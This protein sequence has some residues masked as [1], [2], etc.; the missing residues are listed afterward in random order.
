MINTVNFMEIVIVNGI[1]ILLMVLL[2]LSRIENIEK[3]FFGD[4]VFDV[5]IWLTIAGCLVEIGTFVID[6]KMFFG[7]RALSYLLNSFCFIGTCT[8]GFLWCLFVD[9]RI[10]NNI[11]RI[12]K[13][14]KILCIPLM[15]DIVMNVINLNGCGIV[16]SISKDNI[17]QRG[18]F[19]ISTYVILFIYFIYSLCLV[20]RSK[21]SDLR[22]RFFPVNYFVLPCVLGTIVQGMIYGVTLGWTMV[23]VAFL[24]VHI[25]TQSLNSFV[26]SLSGLYNRSY[27][28]C[29]LSQ[30]KRNAKGCVYGIMIDVNDFKQINDL[31][32]HTKGDHAIRSVGKIL[33][34]SVSDN[35]IAVRYA[36]DEFIVLIHTEDELFVK[37]TMNYI[38]NK[39]EEFNQKNEEPYHLSFAMGYS[40]FDVKTG[41]VEQFLTEMD[42]Q[43][44][45]SKQLYY[46]NKD[47]K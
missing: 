40:R 23:A 11:N 19:V 28:D 5:M 9:F 38:Q 6:G 27:M 14:A 16:F 2:R 26:D 4:I 25:E 12:R 18:S 32:G 21:K 39:T 8:V 3:R 24:F 47:K 34:E 30:I 10:F 13:K 33:S 22:M 36:G 17:Y 45:L 41:N 31:Y 1:G 37:E 44:Y 29:I 43:M 35:G 15:V 20:D 46:Q 42:R 7:S